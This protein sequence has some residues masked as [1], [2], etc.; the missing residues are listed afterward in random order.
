[1]PH[2]FSAVYR[3][4]DNVSIIKLEV[5]LHFDTISLQKITQCDKLN[6]TISLQKITQCDKLNYTISL[7]K[8]TQCD[9]LIDT[10]FLQKITQCD[11][12]N[13]KV[14]FAENH[15]LTSSATTRFDKLN[16]KV[17]LQKIPQTKTSI[18]IRYLH[19]LLSYFVTLSAAP[20]SAV[21]RRVDNVSIIKLEVCLHFDTI[22]L[23]KITQCDK[24]NYTISLQKIILQQVQQPLSVT[25]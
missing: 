8:I 3:R 23:Q 14:F 12:L 4:V 5:C 13:Y 25:N 2:P 15:T 10:I 16:H 6:Y 22:F 24:L 9:K 1:V 18:S 11:K 21:Y 7:Q 19:H 17:F 20:F